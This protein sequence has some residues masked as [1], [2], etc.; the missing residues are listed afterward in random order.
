MDKRSSLYQYGLYGSLG[1]QIG[2]AIGLCAYAGQWLD[3]KF[4]TTP[5]LTMVGVLLGCVAGF[6]NMLKILNLQKAQA[7]DNDERK[8]D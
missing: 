5:W 8:S 3:S 7:G 2:A 6:M 1:I 4:D